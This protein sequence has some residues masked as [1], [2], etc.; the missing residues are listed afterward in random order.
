[1]E[2]MSGKTESLETVN[3]NNKSL[4]T[5]LEGLVAKLQVSQEHQTIL[6]ET[7]FSDPAQLPQVRDNFPYK[8]EGEKVTLV[9]Q[10]VLAASA[11][12][13][14]LLAPLPFSLTR[15]EAVQEQRKRMDR[16]VFLLKTELK[17]WAHIHL[18]VQILKKKN[19]VTKVPFAENLV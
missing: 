15:M 19:L 2:K 11:L 7:D 13:S 3:E 12:S 6:M 5:E 16:Y 18:H 10:V 17:Y 1:M 9:C 4:M 8:H 14:A